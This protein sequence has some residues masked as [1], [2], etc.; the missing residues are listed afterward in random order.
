[1]MHMMSNL[2][3]PE[4]LGSIVPNILLT[5]MQRGTLGLKIMAEETTVEM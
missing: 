1:M 5:D 4:T 2:E 3:N